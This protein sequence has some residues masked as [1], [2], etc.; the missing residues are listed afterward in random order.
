MVVHDESMRPT[1]LP[2][3]R[4]LVDPAGVRSRVP[5]VGSIVV[6]P[7]PEGAER[8]LVKRVLARPGE[9]TP[10]GTR[11]PPGMVYVIGE[12]RTASRD[13]RSFG[14]V[15]VEALV[16]VAWY[17]YFPTERRGRVDREAVK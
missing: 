11:V 8:L 6:L 13:S 10:D 3:D 16:G 12:D 14:P 4:L 2:G 7:D 17:R 5:A 15:A 9:A 1:L